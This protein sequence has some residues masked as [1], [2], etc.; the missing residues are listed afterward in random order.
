MNASIIA[1]P[2]SDFAVPQ[3]LPWTFDAFRVKKRNHYD[4]RP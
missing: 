3:A 4:W 1:E 2:H